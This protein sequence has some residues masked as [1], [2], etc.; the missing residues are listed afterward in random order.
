MQLARQHTRRGTGHHDLDLLGVQHAPH[1]PLPPGHELNLVEEPVHHLAPAQ[2]RRAPVIFF[3]QEAELFPAQAGQPVV[4]ETE[5]ERPLGRQSC[6]PRV[7]QL[8]QEGGLAGA[9][10]ADHRVHLARHGGQLCV[11]TRQGRRRNRRQRGAEFLRQYGMQAHGR[12][13]ALMCPFFKDT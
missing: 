10:H 5:I 9:A 13:I 8:L 12:S 2:C 6:A 4:V 3:E 1:E 7:Q 11:A